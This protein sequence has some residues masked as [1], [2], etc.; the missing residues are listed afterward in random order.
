[1]DINKAILEM[2]LHHAKSAVIYARVGELPFFYLFPLGVEMET[3][4][5]VDELPQL[6]PIVETLD[7]YNRVVVVTLTNREAR[8]F[9]TTAGTVTNELLTERPDLGEMIGRERYHNNREDK[10]LKLING[11]IS[12]L[13]ELMSKSEND[14]LIVAGGPKMVSAFTKA[15]PSRLH[16]MLLDTV[17][18]NPKAGIDP[19]MVEA[20]Q[21]FAKCENL[22][23]HDRVRKLESAVLNKGL[24]VAGEDSVIQ[25][26]IH[27]Y[28]DVLVIDQDYP[29]HKREELVRLALK[30]E[31]EIE[32][33]KSSQ[34]L[35][36]LD[37]V[38]CLLRYRPAYIDVP[39]MANAS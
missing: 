30:T 32:T 22:E 12:T 14:S 8:I 2:P 21:T 31:A 1:M 38:G 27:G 5:V 17:D 26:L 16:N 3:K 23:S 25:A 7:V 10:K 11:M 19:I 24:G 6:Y 4:L 13:D 34:K 20:I 18:M 15:L 39:R 29:E 36:K 9:E 28:A 35:K 37:G 33:V